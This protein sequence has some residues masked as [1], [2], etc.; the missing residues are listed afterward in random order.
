VF[1]RRAPHRWSI[2]PSAAVA[3]QRRLAMQVAQGPLARPVRLVAGA[4]A[5]FVV[6]DALCVAGVV[7]WDVATQA[8]VEQRVAVR[9]LTFPYIP[10]L[11]SFR[12]APAVLAALRRLR[13]PPDV[14][15]C[16]AHGLA[17]PRRFGLACHVGVITGLPTLG[18]AKSRLVGSH[19]TPARQRGG[20]V[21]LRH[22][23]EVVGTVLR[24][25]TG[26]RPLFV[27]VG[28][29]IDLAGAEAVVL[30][31]ATRYR[32]PEPTRRADALVA[33]ARRRFLDSPIPRG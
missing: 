32:L 5:A 12:E 17:H 23:G 25:Q 15:I 4:D 7:L 14:L 24:T 27:S 16:D 19:D 20:R 13:T 21:P 31:C 9:P 33:A 29:R 2:S 30:A 3:I 11:L 28:H 26:A 10:G 22:D 6:A 8:A 1:I 18:C